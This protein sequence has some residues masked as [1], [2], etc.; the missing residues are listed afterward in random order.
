MSEAKLEAYFFTAILLVTLLVVAV[1][2]YPFIGSLALAL[3]LATLVAPFHT[4]LLAR[5]HN[6]TLSA[7][8]VTLLATCAIILPAIGLI[9]LLVDEIRSISQSITSYD[10]NVIPDFISTY[11]A[12]FI[13][14]IPLASSI[15]ISE[16]VQTSLQN[17]GTHFA[18]VITSTTS[19]IL[20]FFVALIALYYFIKD[21]KRFVHELIHLSPL[22]D[23]EDEAIVHKIDRVTHSLIRGTLV[24]AALKGLFVGLGFLLFGIPN[25]VL[26]GSFAAISAL[27]PTLGTGIVTAPAIIYLFVTGQIAEG[28]GL[29]AW[30][31]VIVGLV[32]N[33]L[34]PKLIGGGAKIH[35]LFV[36]ISVLGGLAV[37]GIAGF[38]L[39]PLIFGFLVALAEIYKV[40]INELHEIALQHD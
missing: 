1:I 24:I 17:L 36:L 2:F 13:E 27:I 7:L 4:A 3:V 28:I 21:G 11:Q 26:W 14:T 8:T 20:K 6:E 19:M 37:F 23:S 29:T 40:K 10:L 31:V 34:E 9:I 35:P 30:S 25:P 39:G 38:L 32:D 22:N 12:R 5:T 15:N 16:I 33:I 18:G